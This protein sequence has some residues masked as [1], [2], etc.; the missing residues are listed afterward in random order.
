MSD[1]DC[2]PKF[3]TGLLMEMVA[4]RISAG[5]GIMVAAF[6]LQ[7]HISHCLD[8]QNDVECIEVDNVKSVRKDGCD[9]TTDSQWRWQIVVRC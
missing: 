6:W 9:D 7:D 5:I 3:H 1:L 4:T 8:R 2:V